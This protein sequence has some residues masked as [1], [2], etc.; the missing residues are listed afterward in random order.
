[1]TPIGSRLKALG[2]TALFFALSSAL[3]LGTIWALNALPLPS[4]VRNALSGYAPHNSIAAVSD[5]RG[6]VA[7]T[8]A[9]LAASALV[10]A[11]NS[12]YCDRM[13]A[14]FADVLLMMVAAMAGF[15]GG[16][17]VMLR[18]AGYDN[19]LSSPYLLS[20]LLCPAII[21]LV[22]VIN[23]QRLRAS[24]LLRWTATLAL[25]LAGPALLLWA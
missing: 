5:L 3:L 22:S 13:L 20:T 18:L 6:V 16:Y 23:P 10:L 15:V 9:F 17:W 4:A 21:F 12:D 2:V 14:I 11:F 19:F 8:S 7:L 24:L 1:M 25:L